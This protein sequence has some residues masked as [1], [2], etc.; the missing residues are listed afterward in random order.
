MD[1]YLDYLRDRIDGL[2][3]K[4]SWQVDKL[5]AAR[6]EYNRALDFAR[7]NGLTER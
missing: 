7:R 6:A 4:P 1:S 3:S 5:A 2:M